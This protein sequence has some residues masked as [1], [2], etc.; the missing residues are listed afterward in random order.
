MIKRDRTVTYKVDPEFEEDVDLFVDRAESTCAI[1]SKKMLDK[2]LK[3]DENSNNEIVLKNIE[4]IK[5]INSAHL[6][7]T[8]EELEEAKNKLKEL[9]RYIN[10]VR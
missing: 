10:E 3:L 1:F 2:G 5:L 9:R 7:R 6:F 4:L 8:A